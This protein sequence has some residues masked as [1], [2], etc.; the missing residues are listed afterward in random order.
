ML[1]QS[2]VRFQPIGP[3]CWK[4]V[5]NNSK[6]PGTPDISLGGS[7]MTGYREDVK[8]P[9]AVTSPD[10]YSNHCHHK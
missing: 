6:T 7:D 9:A 1:F 3:L 8:L 4:S 2:F 10:Q 5:H